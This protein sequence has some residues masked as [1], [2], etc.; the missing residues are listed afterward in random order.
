MSI[1]IN[2]INMPTNCAECGFK[3]NCDDCEGYE[4]FCTVLHRDIGYM[5][6]NSSFLSE[7]A[8]IVPSDC[9]LDDCPL[10][11]VPD[12][13]RLIDADAFLDDLLFPSKQFEL[14]M[15]ELIGDAPTII[16]GES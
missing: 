8:P 15:R 13:G 11:Q 3:I 9:R 7:N 14:G 2:G 16:E 6:H 5:P 4:C 12:H 10:I 1:L